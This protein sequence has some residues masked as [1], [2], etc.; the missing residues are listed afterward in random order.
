MTKALSAISQA[1]SYHFS[2]FQ[3]LFFLFFII[4]TA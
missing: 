1:I 3:I 2:A 4:E